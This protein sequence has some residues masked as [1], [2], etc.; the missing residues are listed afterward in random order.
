L[1][2]IKQKCLPKHIST[3][4]I[5]WLMTIARAKNIWTPMAYKT[6]DTV[7]AGAA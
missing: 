3:K 2:L 6:T 5:Y 4:K 7:L 1:E